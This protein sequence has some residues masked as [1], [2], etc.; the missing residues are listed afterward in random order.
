MQELLPRTPG[1]GA[2]R[3][4]PKDAAALLIQEGASYVL[5]SFMSQSAQANAG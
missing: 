1:R 4:D 5:A 2:T 3:S